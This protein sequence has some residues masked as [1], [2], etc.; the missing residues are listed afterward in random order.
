MDFPIVNSWE[1]EEADRAKAFSFRPLFPK[2]EN[3]M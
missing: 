2:W 1:A 3:C